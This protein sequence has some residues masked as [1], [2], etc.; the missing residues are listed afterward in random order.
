MQIDECM[1]TEVISA[2]ADISLERAVGVLV[3]N[4]IGTL[5]LVDHNGKL[6]GLLTL[7]DLLQLFL[8]DFVALLETLAFVPDFGAVSEPDI[9]PELLARS[10]REV[11]RAPTAVESG[12]PVLRAS[13]E[14]QKSDLL[15]VCVIDHTGRLV[16]IASRTDVGTAVLADWL[17]KRP[18]GGR[19]PE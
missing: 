17:S 1:K 12:T 3:W 7:N 18:G 5:P 16:G 10:V 13:A 9:P 14:F 8:P 4:G 2:S 6:I 15:D 11:M 19:N